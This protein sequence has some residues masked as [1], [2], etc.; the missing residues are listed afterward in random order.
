M[1]FSHKI[2]QPRKFSSQKKNPGCSKQAIKLL[3]DKTFLIPDLCNFLLFF[4]YNLIHYLDKISVS[5]RGKVI[6]YTKQTINQIPSWQAPYFCFIA[7]HNSLKKTTS[8]KLYVK[9]RH[10]SLVS[11]SPLMYFSLR[12]FI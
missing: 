4:S 2:Y 8:I 5:T 9:V 7:M 6:I 10:N 12:F 1:D 11:F 3:M